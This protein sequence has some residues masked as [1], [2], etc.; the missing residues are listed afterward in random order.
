[1]EEL[2]ATDYCFHFILP[3]S[4]FILCLDPLRH[5]VAVVVYEAGLA[6]ERLRAGVGALD[7]EVEGADSERAADAFDELQG[8]PARAAPARFRS[9]VKLVEEGVAPA[10]L[11]A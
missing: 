10:E 3:P 9:Q 4:S 1:M 6:V 8:L 2:P 11:E 5:E 7:F